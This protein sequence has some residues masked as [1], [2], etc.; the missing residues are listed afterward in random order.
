MEDLAEKISSVLSDP[1]SMKQ[2]SELAQMLGLPAEN[3]PVPQENDGKPNEQMP[4]VGAIMN[5]AAKIKEAGQNDDN[6][7][8]LNALRP[9]LSDEKKPKI[10]RAIKI[11][12]LLNILPALK[13][14][15]LMGG[16]LFGIL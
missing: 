2:L 15:G 12:K 16:D 6:I 8:F 13:D 11:L 9:L 10:D 14:S 3:I 7:N 5:L 1:E 4:D